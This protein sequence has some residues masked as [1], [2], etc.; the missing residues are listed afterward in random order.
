MEKKCIIPFIKKKT[1]QKHKNNLR[2]KTKHFKTK[3][4]V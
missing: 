3:N 2:M 1:T 4:V